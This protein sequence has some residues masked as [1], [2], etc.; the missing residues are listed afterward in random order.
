MYTVCIPSH[1]RILGINETATILLKEL[2]QA[3]VRGET[4]VQKLI[5]ERLVATG[6]LVEEFE[7]DPADVKVKGEFAIDQARAKDRRKAI[8]GTLSGSPQLPSLLVFAHPDGEMIGDI[9]QW[10]HDPF[11]GSIENGRLFGWGVADDLAGCAAAVAALESIANSDKPMGSVIF[12]STPSKRHARGVSALLH[13]NIT[14]DASLYLHPAESGSGMREIKAVASGHMEFQIIVKGC[15]PETTEPGHTAFSHLAENPIDKALIIRSALVRL[16]E[17]RAKRVRYPQIEALVGRATNLHVSKI[18]CGDMCRLSRIEDT[19]IL[20]CAVSFPPSETINQVKVEIEATI[21]K[22]VEADNWLRDHP[23]QVVWVS[24]VTGGEVSTDH[25]LYQTAAAA[26]LKITGEAPS[27]NPM[28]TSSDIRNPIVEAGIPC[29]GLGCLAGDLSQNN[30]H[31]EWIDLA[32][33]HRMVEVTKAIVADW[34]SGF[35]PDPNQEKRFNQTSNIN[36]ER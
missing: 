27:N 23:P 19:C 24:G 34:C 10:R 36:K 2:C 12:A 3:Q 4:A 13:N 17:E 29:I 26:I 18:T 11:A 35:V 1:Q 16:A 22:A 28:H 8:V 6:C 7:Y 33:F 21:G 14:A 31:D 5:S 32:D 20:G 9:S 15:P 30:S 25:P